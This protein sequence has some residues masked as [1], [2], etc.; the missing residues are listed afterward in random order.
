MDRLT[1]LERLATLEVKVGNIEQ[2]A[3]TIKGD[4]KLLL[5]ANAKGQG[6]LSFISRVAPWAALSAAIAG[7]VVR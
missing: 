4:V 7:L 3:T 6:V 1:I 2:D 5:L